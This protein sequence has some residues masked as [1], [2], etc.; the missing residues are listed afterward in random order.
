MLLLKEVTNICSKKTLVCM[1]AQKQAI[2]A[3]KESRRV[4]AMRH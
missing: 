3:E 4:V 1:E 2:E